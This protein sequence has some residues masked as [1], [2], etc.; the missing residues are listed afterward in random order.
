MATYS[1][2]EYF[3]KVKHVVGL[4]FYYQQNSDNWNESVTTFCNIAFTSIYSSKRSHFNYC[5][6]VTTS[7]NITVELFERF[8]RA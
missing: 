6:I 8:E 1:I 5:D 2:L 3:D 7:N 4:I